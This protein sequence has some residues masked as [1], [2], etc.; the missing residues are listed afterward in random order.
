MKTLLS[1]LLVLSMPTSLAANAL[2]ISTAEDLRRACNAADRFAQ[3]TSYL[4]VVFD[5]AKAISHMQDSKPIEVVGSCG[6]DKGIDTV[7]LVISL[8]AAW[9]EYAAKYPDRLNRLA[10]AEALHAFETRWPCKH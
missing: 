7:P 4:K 8:R 3:C 5:T 2:G 10:V 1:I 6:P 9:Q